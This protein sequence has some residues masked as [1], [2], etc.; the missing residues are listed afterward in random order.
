MRDVILIITFHA[1]M[2]RTEKNNAFLKK[3]SRPFLN[4][5]VF[6]YCKK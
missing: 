2:L 3:T 5:D 1:L 4:F 6:N